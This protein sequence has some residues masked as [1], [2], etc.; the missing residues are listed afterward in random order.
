MKIIEMQNYKSF[1]YYTQLEE[2]LKPSRMAL[3]NHPLYQQLND[4]VSLQ[5]FMESHVFAVWDF[6]S[7]I[8]TLQHRVTCLDVPWVPPTDIN[9]ARMVNE[10]VL[11]EETD[12]VSPGNYISHYDLYMVAMTEIG[13]D[14]NPI[15]TFISSLRKGIPAEQ[16]IASISIPEL[17]KTFVK[18]TLETTTKSTHEVAAAFLLGREDII[19]AMFRQVIA[20]LDS[21]YGFTWDSLRLYLDR[22]NF[23]DED[24]HVP[25]GKK[26]LKNLCGDD[27]VKWEQAFN[28]AENALKAR[29]ALWDGVAELIQ[30]NKENDIALL[31]M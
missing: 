2:Q 7:L 29:Y 14:T 23:L 18:F 3:I 11:A 1:D 31:E 15:K 17:T 24:Q 19:P 13:A 28:S 26:L 25:M 27:P 6:M 10:I 30:L 4:L 16:T 9:S 21:L 22:H 20:T 8:K 12:E 5:I